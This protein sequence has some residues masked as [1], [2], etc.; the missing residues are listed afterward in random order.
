MIKIKRVYTLDIGSGQ[1][2]TFKSHSNF[3][4]KHKI[5][6]Q[7]AIP[8]ICIFL[9][10]RNLYCLKW[11]TMGGS[12]IY[13]TLLCFSS[14]HLG[15]RAT[16][17]LQI[18]HFNLLQPFESITLGNRPHSDLNDFTFLILSTQLWVEYDW[19]FLCRTKTWTQLS[20][21]GKP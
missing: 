2:L 20:V 21:Q 6:K 15:T 19:V 12:T 14:F 3:N 4:S 11:L 5:T 16:G 9:H 10:G 13:F 1:L 17:L 18:N 7:F 8:M